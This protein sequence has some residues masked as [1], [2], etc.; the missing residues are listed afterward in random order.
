MF[1]SNTASGAQFNVGGGTGEEQSVSL[2][3]Y[4]ILVYKQYDHRDC[5]IW[6]KKLHNI[7]TSR[8]A[9]TCT[10]YNTDY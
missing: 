2:Y 6:V 1:G 4:V 5:M 3:H 7:M 10:Q 8:P 9:K